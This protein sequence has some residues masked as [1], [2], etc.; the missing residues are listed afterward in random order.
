M[1]SS[2][3]PVAFRRAWTSGILIISSSTSTE[4][5]RSLK[6]LEQRDHVDGGY[7]LRVREGQAVELVDIP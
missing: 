7:V 6:L 5:C 4:F 2:L 3:L 1:T